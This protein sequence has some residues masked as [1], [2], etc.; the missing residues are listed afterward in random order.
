MRSIT[1]LLGLTGLLS[2]NASAQSLEEAV[3]QTLLTNP[4]IQTSE[5]NLQA[6]T[7][8][9]RQ[10]FAGFLP[11]VDVVFA[12]GL[13]ESDNTTTRAT[14]LVNQRF[15]RYERSLVLNQMVYD[16]FGT[17]NYVKQQ[18]AVMAAT[19]ARVAT[20]RENTSLQVAQAYLEVLRTDQLVVLS[21]QNLV[22]HEE[23]LS[24]IEE[25]FEGG[26]GTKV[27]VVQTKGRQAQSKS[28]ML[29]SQKDAQNSRA[30]FY[31]VVGESAVD[32]VLPSRPITLPETLEAAVQRA[33]QKNPQV[34]A[35]QADLEAARAA[36]KQ[37]L[38]AFQPRVDLTLGA[39]RNDNM[40][41]SPGPNDD[42]TAVLRMSY[43]LYRG[44][45]DKARL[46]EAVV[47]ISSAEQG[48]IA[49]RR[50]ITK[51]VSL[52]WNDIEDL[53]LRLEYL[54]VHVTATEEVLEVYLE[55][56]AIGKRT[57]LDV[58]DIQ[59]ELFRARSGL[60]SAEFQLRIAEF[61]LLATGGQFLESLGL[62]AR[63]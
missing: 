37:I 29:L 30:Q 42:Q 5:F 44:G 3:Q 32:L 13:E 23:T 1:I 59:N 16:G 14:E 28:S 41:G 39:T 49:L 35:A 57:L 47:R 53:G 10:A 45:A 58:L 27:D 31:R 8:L 51:D 18:D 55:Q 61:R 50:S 2:V 6:A 12:R 20:T 62:S 56:L 46:T 9:R 48:L 40:D 11:S 15:D 22:Q 52:L 33:F 38:G 60:V 54:Q 34:E 26:V 36:R 19:A 63:S 21:K 25:R 4:N 7:A 24:K 17:S 43:N